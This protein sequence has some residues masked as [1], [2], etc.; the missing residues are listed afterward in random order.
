MAKPRPRRIA[1]TIKL[2]P[3][4]IDAVIFARGR[5]GW[6]NRIYNHLDP[7]TGEVGL[8]ES[9]AW[10]WLEDVAG[11][12]EGNHAPFPLAGDTLAEKLWHLR[13]RIV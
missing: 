13:G 6:P 7:K 2:T 4:E 11:D 3:G 8:T 12:E 5:Y 9:E 1:Y 10:S